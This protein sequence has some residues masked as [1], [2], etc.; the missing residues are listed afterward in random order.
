MTTASVYPDE[1]QGAGLVLRPWTADLV[2]QLAVWGEYG[3]PFHSF[4]LGY[5]RDPARAR[6][7]L[8]WA[9]GPGPHRHFIACEG[10]TAVGRVS[11][12]LRDEAGLYLWAVHVP[13][14]HQGRGVCRRMLA[15][16][17]GWLEARYPHGTGFVLSTNAFAE[18]AHRAYRAIGFEVAETRWHFDRQLAEE[19]WK[20]TPAQREP[21]S[22][23][24]RFY[25]GRW[26]VRIHLMRRPFGAGSPG[27][28]A[29]SAP[30]R[31]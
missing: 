15:A 25:N 18:H 30:A 19:L 17:L 16:L 10:D 26:E 3:F 14:E 13:P 7:T 20:A 11:V 23:H 28:G 29:T 27:G 2:A 21:I 9:Q 22:R 1:I 31:S 5:L 6:D 12:N 24:I 4:D 8:A